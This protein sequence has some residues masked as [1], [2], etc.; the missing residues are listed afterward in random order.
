MHTP[1]VV[2][3]GEVL[4]DLFPDSRV[5][6]GAPFNFASHLSKLGA[7]VT[8]ISAVGQDDLGEAAAEQIRKMGMA[9]TCTTRLAEYP[10]GFCKVTLHNGTPSYDLKRDVAY[11]HIPFPAACPKK[12][13]ALYCGTLASRMSDSFATLRRLLDE[14]EAKEVF[15]DVNIRGNDWSEELLNTVLPYTTVLKFSREESAVMAEALGIAGADLC[16]A[17]CKELAKRY[18]RIKQILVTLDK[19]GSF[20]YLAAEDR[21]LYSPKPGSEAVST[22]GAGDSFS[23]CYVY[24]LL[25]GADTE[26]CLAR[27]TALSDYVVT[28]LGAVPEYPA[29]LIA[30]IK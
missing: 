5:I 20:V 3:F 14:V 30:K 12:A 29:E 6:G 17:M 24:N 1:S 25:T 7:E 21:I 28:Q 13:D 9:D 16:T 18:P 2:S 26:T 8:F 11:D 10:T 19:D 23:A 27:A 22:V 4:W 15:F